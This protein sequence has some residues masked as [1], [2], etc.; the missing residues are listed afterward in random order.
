[1]SPRAKTSKRTKGLD[2]ARFGPFA[3]AFLAGCLATVLILWGA[4]LIHRGHSPS[5][6]PEESAAL[7]EGRV[8]ALS[9]LL[10]PQADWRRRELS[11][12]MEWIGQ[13]SS[14]ESL[15]QWNAQVS[16]GIRGLGLEVLEGR[17]EVVT[18]PGKWPL[19]RLTLVVGAAGEALAT[20]IV[21]TTRS[22]TLPAAF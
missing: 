17:E 4:G 13:V 11:I 2:P 12:P 20:I 15:V 19:Q 22:P 1:M 7:L 3:L 6:S 14:S 9:A 21:E 16:A 8:A 10:L 5:A 18:R